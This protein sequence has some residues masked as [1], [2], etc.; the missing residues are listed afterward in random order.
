MLKFEKKK[1]DA[2]HGKKAF[3]IC[4]NRWEFES[5]QSELDILWHTTISN[6]F[7]VNVQADQIRACI[8]RK[9]R[10]GPFR[11]LSI[12]HLTVEDTV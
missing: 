7:C 9:L 10:K 6:K 2:W 8:V 11:V 4:V 3:I 5:V 12:N 1:N